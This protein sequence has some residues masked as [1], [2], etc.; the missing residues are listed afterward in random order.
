[1]M[2]STDNDKSIVEIY[3]T[4]ARETKRKIHYSLT[5]HKGTP[6]HG[7]TSIIKTLYIPN[8]EEGNTYLVAYHNPYQFE[9]AS[10]FFGVFFYSK[11][12]TSIQIDIR[13]KDILDTLNPFLKRKTMQANDSDFNSKTVIYAHEGH[14][15][16]KIINDH[17]IQQSILESLDIAQ[18][19][20]VGMNNCYIDFIPEF[21]GKSPF[22]IYSKQKWHTET[23]VME[24]MYT[25]CERLRELFKQNNLL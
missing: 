17:K 19:L 12:D 23:A 4:F 21:I 22:G 8:K 2:D 16:E 13:K 11:V 10:I 1:M 3:E 14:I 24:N 18:V 6:L 9:D 5:P 20:H 7:V 25:Q 15:T